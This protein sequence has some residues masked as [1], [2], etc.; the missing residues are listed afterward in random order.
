MRRAI[1]EHDR[2]S[3]LKACTVSKTSFRTVD[4]PAKLIAP[5]RFG[6]LLMQSSIIMI[7][8]DVL[9]GQQCSA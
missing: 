6:G 1:S 4:V 8:L 5:R 2:P 9:V 7:N 3:L